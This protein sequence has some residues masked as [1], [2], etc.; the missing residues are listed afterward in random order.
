M[1]ERV[2][3]LLNA[4]A[5]PPQ[6]KPEPRWTV[7]VCQMDDDPEAA[8]QWLDADAQQAGEKYAAAQLKWP[9]IG[10]R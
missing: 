8:M 7:P 6:P 10:A 2:E 3:R 4:L 1:I 9:G 5:G